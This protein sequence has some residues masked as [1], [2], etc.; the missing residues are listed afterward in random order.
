M[1]YEVLH[2]TEKNQLV[3]IK[4]NIIEYLDFRS[5]KTVSTDDSID[6]D[7]IVGCKKGF[8][9]LLKNDKYTL[10]V[11]KASDCSLKY[12][13][14]LEEEII[15][16]SDISADGSSVLIKTTNTYSLWNIEESVLLKIFDN[17]YHISKITMS[18]DAKYLAY[19]KDDA[20]IYV[21]DTLNDTESQLKSAFFFKYD[22]ENDIAIFMQ[23]ENYQVAITGQMSNNDE[24][25]ANLLIFDIKQ[26]KLMSNSVVSPTPRVP[27]VNHIA[28]ITDKYIILCAKYGFMDPSYIFWIAN[29]STGQ[30]SHNFHLSGGGTIREQ[31]DSKSEFLLIRK[32]QQYSGDVNF[33]AIDINNDESFIINSN[34]KE[35]IP[36]K[37]YK[38]VGENDI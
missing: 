34:G 14:S 5:C 31:I 18:D 27:R 16:I 35:F 6:T 21:Y 7:S 29:I 11:L 33:E 12:S 3:T 1:N 32:L 30:Y 37:S 17:S 24:V 25:N 10:D 9:F 8:I 2:L 23:N 38:Q 36:F 4:Q 20:S 15:E 26:N 13:I 22:W 28:R 19:I